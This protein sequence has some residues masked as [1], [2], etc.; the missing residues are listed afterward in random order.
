MELVADTTNVQLDG[1]HA[2]DA[3]TTVMRN[4][5]VTMVGIDCL[6]PGVTMMGRRCHQPQFSHLY[7][8][9]THLPS[10]ASPPPGCLNTMPIS[11]CAEN[12]NAGI[13]DM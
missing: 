13:N 1:G 8:R 5:E 2:K 11:I 7:L 9:P 3:Y 12:G 6:T 10:A 4:D